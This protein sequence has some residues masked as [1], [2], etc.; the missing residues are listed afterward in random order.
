MSENSDKTNVTPAKAEPT[1]VR[2]RRNVSPRALIRQTDKNGQ[3]PQSNRQ[4]AKGKGGKLE[5]KASVTIPIRIRVGLNESRPSFVPDLGEPLFTTDDRRFWVGDG[6][7]PGGIPVSVSQWPINDISEL[8]SLEDAEI[9]DFAF[10]RDRTRCFML[11]NPPPSS[12]VAWMEL[13]VEPLQSDDERKA[14]RYL[15]SIQEYL[16]DILIEERFIVDDVNRLLPKK[17]T[18]AKI[19]KMMNDRRVL[20]AYIADVSEDKVFPELMFTGYAKL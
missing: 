16:I 14:K 6:E 8:A 5:R 20:N 12:K 17:V 2:S 11:V 10:Y 7:T 4:P 3:L 19:A 9:G 15:N 1:N 13:Q 18:D